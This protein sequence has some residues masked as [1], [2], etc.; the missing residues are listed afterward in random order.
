MLSKF[1][2]KIG[3]PEDKYHVNLAERKTLWYALKK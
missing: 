1:D 2:M 3:W